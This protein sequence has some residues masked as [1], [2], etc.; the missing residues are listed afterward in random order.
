MTELEART[1][2]LFDASMKRSLWN[3]IIAFIKGKNSK[4]KE[5][6]GQI[7]KEVTKREKDALYNDP[8]IL[9]QRMKRF[10]QGKQELAILIEEMAAK[11]LHYLPAH[12]LARARLKQYNVAGGYNP[13]PIFAY[14]LRNPHLRT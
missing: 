5:R 12:R 7:E 13:P 4:Y 11:G 3:S 9:S 2:V 10:E 14:L 8:E 6:I 1:N